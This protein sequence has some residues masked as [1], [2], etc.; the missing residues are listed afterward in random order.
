[1]EK[2]LHSQQIFADLHYVAGPHGED[3]VAGFGVF[4]EVVFDFV[5]GFKVEAV[6]AEGL[7][8]F[9]QVGR[10]DAYGV[11][12]SGGVDGGQD[13][14]I[15]HGQGI[16]EI[17]QEGVGPAVG[18]RLEY[19][20]EGLFV[21]GISCCQGRADLRGMVGVIINDGDVAKVSFVFKT[22]FGAAEGIEASLNG[23]VIDAE[24]DGH[25]DHG[26]SIG[27]IVHTRYVQGKGSKLCAFSQAGKSGAAI[28][29]ESDIFGGVV[30]VAA[31]TEGD[32]LAV[33]IMGNS[34]YFRGICIDDQGTILGQKLGEA[35]KGMADIVNIFKEIQ[36]ICV[37]VQNDGDLRE[38]A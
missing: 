18:V 38:K 26:Q 21:A 32:N 35:V 1:M 3:D 33:Q 16:C 17:V 8:L 14:L 28:F 22:A 4:E 5:E 24:A 25:G 30:S 15:G 19:A 27:Y 29:I 10:G 37:H 9:L 36:M 7:D 6:F 2:D 23:I 31:Q 12:F 11:V 20:P 34:L 13:D